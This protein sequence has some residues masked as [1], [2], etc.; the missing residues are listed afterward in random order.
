MGKK[1]EHFDD[2]SE[3]RIRRAEG[4][5]RIHLRQA[6]IGIHRGIQKGYGRPYD[7]STLTKK[8][9]RKTRRKKKT[10]VPSMGQLFNPAIQAVLIKHNFSPI[11]VS[12]LLFIHKTF[13]LTYRR[14]RGR[15]KLIEES[16]L[17]H[18]QETGN[19]GS[20]KNFEQNRSFLKS[21]R[22]VTNG[23]FKRFQNTTEIG[24]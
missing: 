15:K 20:R 22:F 8:R 6:V 9:S 2:L 16:S 3:E 7:P 14:K 19:G 21:L 5:V 13:K 10:E 4:E 11:A 24:Y 1:I 18:I 17:V 23:K 12:L